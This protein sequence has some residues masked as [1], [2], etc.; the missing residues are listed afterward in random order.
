LGVQITF[1]RISSIISVKMVDATSTTL[2]FHPVP[3][4]PVIKL[5]AL[6]IASSY[7]AP[8]NSSQSDNPPSKTPLG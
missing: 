7:F 4:Y 1:I 5:L 8:T 3:N 6:A 2:P